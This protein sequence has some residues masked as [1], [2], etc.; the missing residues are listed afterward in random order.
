MTTAPQTALT[1]EQVLALNP[2]DADNRRKLF[3]KH[4]GAAMTASEAFAAGVSLRDLLWVAVKIGKR[5][6]V[7][8]F[9]IACVQRIV[10]PKTDKRVQACLDAA[11]AYLDNKTPE[12][13]A[14]LQTARKASYAAYAA[15]AYSAYAAATAAAAAA[16]SAY[17]AATAAAAAATDVDAA[18]DAA[19]FDAVA[20]DAYYYSAARNQEL[21]VQKQL[22]IEMVG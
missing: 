16:Y 15:A 8:R 1:L 7:A 10:T 17:A 21:E 18:V 4:N 20:F 14:A 13:L 2:C 22:F 19:A 12:T 11:L 5:D 9:A 6:Q 3:A